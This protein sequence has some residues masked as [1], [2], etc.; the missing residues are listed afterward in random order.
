MFTGATSDLVPR[1]FNILDEVPL[2]SRKLDPNNADGPFA[3]G[4]LHESLTDPFFKVPLNRG[5]HRVEIRDND[6]WKFTRPMQKN[7]YMARYG[8]RRLENSW[9]R[10]DCSISSQLNVTCDAVVTK[11]FYPNM[12]PEYIGQSLDSEPKW[13][14]GKKK[15]ELYM[16]TGFQVGKGLRFTATTNVGL[17][18]RFGFAAKEIEHEIMPRM[19]NAGIVSYRATKYTLFRR[20]LLNQWKSRDLDHGDWMIR[21]EPVLVRDKDAAVLKSYKQNPHEAFFIG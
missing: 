14:D 18:S 8:T 10:I 12:I 16:I 15:A 4:T 5:P 2:D 11:V 20:N 21:G 6:V 17:G 1:Y 9:I 3:L 13:L 7:Q 19:D